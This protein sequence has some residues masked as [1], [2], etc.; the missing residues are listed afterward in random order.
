MIVLLLLAIS[1]TLIIVYLISEYIHLVKLRDIPGPRRLPLVGNFLQIDRKW[2]NR[3]FLAWAK[4]YGPIYSLK[5]LNDAWLIVTGY[6]ELQEMLVTKGHMFAGRPTNL[7]SSIMSIGGKDVAFGGPQ[8]PQWMAMRKTLHRAIHHYGEGMIRLDS[9]LAE[10]VQDFVL[11]LTKYNGQTVD[12]RDDFRLLISHVTISLLVGQKLDDSDPIVINMK[13]LV[14]NTPEILIPTSSIVDYYPLLRFFTYDFTLTKAIETRNLAEQ[15]SKDLWKIGQATYTSGIDQP[16]CGVHA[17]AQLLDERSKFY[18]PAITRDNAKGLMFDVLGSA[19][20]SSQILYVIPNILHHYPDV[21]SRLQAEVDE[22]VGKNRLPNIA[23]R[24]AMPYTVATVFE[25][26]RF[27]NVSAALPHVAL[28]DT[29]IGQYAIP[30][31]TV[32]YPFLG[33]LQLDEIFWGDPFTFRPE[34]YLNEDGSLLPADH[35][36]RKHT[37]PFGLG[38]RA[39]LGEAFA[40]KRLF[41]ILATIAQTIDLHP[42]ALAVCHPFQYTKGLVIYQAP[43]TSI[44]LLRK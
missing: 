9:L 12:L 15:L 18:N 41:A 19:V 40:L 35:P 21:Q 24:E 5:I 38:P 43:Y 8:Q 44:P 22:V 42:G 3:S 17:I 7:L 16:K 30:A 2:P 39:C 14:K 37:I 29:T 10:V 34:R 4:E 27:A 20:S 1:F 32:L 36:H 11:K 25:T 6:E 28:A 26:L 33:A 23:D 13:Q 31:G